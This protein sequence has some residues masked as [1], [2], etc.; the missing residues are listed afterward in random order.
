MSQPGQQYQQIPS[1]SSVEP[2]EVRRRSMSTPPAAQ[3]GT[4]WPRTWQD[5][6]NWA[7][8]DP[9]VAGSLTGGWG[10]ERRG[11]GAAEG[12]GDPL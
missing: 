10:C 8:R 6:A 3:G 1:S 4:S 12:G 9:V 5:A 11:A 7:A 2:P